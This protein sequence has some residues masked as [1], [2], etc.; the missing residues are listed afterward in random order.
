VNLFLFYFG[1][2]KGGNMSGGIIIALILVG[3]CWVRSLLPKRMRNYF[4]SPQVV[5]VKQGLYK[6]LGI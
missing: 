5:A 3:W 1:W 2:M 4:L 6:I